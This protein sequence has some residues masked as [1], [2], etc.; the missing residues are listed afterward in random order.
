MENNIKTKQTNQKKIIATKDIVRISLITAVMCVLS[1]IK[2]PMPSGVPLTLQTFAIAI[3]G[4]ILGKKYGV[5]SVILYIILGS[6]GVPV[7]SG[8]IGWIASATSGFIVGFLFISYFCGISL[9]YSFIGLIICHILGFW[10]YS[11]I[12]N[13]PIIASFVSVSAPYIIKDILSILLAY[14]VSKKLK[15]KIQ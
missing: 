4:F 15:S 9:S 3:S 2:I 11:S 14:F 6:I 5:V 7:F 1:F 12:T 8:G 13:T 10:R